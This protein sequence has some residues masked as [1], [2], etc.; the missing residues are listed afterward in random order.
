[1]RMLPS[2][3]I[4]IL[5]IFAVSGIAQAADLPLPTKTPPAPPYVW[6]G[7][8][9]GSN[10]GYGWGHTD[11]TGSSSSVLLGV[12]T[13][14]T[15]AGSLNSNGVLGGGQIGFNYQFMPHWVAGIEAD[16]DGAAING[17]AN[18]CSA[19]GAG[20]VVGCETAALKL[21]DFGT[22]RGRLGYAWN[23][24][25][26]FGTGGFAW[27]QNS[28]T[29]AGTCVGPGCPGAP[30]PFVSNSPST[31]TT[32]PGWAAGA[33][34]EWGFLSNWTLRLE[35]LHLGF[36]GVTTNYIFSGTVIGLPFTTTTHTSANSGV[37]LVRLGVNYVFNWPLI[38]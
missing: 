18:T 26:L 17:S 31:S 38:R 14:S 22:V 28:A 13:P 20:V 9:V 30:L 35:Y 24:V 16:I 32:F 1:M 4:G 21:T 7:F 33:G 12:T 15:F 6:T 11:V 23:N 27:G 34:A 2:L 10:F 3:F 29:H 19:T 36:N 37:D 5:A 8:Y 25:L